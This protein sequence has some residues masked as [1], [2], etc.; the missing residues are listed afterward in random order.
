MSRYAYD[1]ADG[2]SVDTRDQLV[3]KLCEFLIKTR[4]EV[5]DTCSDCNHL[6]EGQETDIKP[7]WPAQYAFQR[8]YGA[9]E[10]KYCLL[11]RHTTK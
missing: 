1:I 2:N 3:Y 8:S 10:L 4:H 9:Y 7:F 6:M 5:C 11:L